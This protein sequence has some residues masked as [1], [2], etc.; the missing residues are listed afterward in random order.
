MEF[1]ID[2]GY[3]VFARI[4]DLI[5]F[6]EPDDYS[7]VLFLY[8][9]IN[10][11]VALIVG[12]IFFFIVLIILIK[13]FRKMF[14]STKPRPSRK[15]AI[16]LIDNSSLP[17]NIIAQS[18]GP[19]TSKS[20]LYNISDN[21]EDKDR[22]WLAMQYKEEERS[23]ATCIAGEIV[24]TIQAKPMSAKELKRSHRNDCDAELNYQDH[25]RNHNKQ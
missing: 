1:F 25:R 4:F 14:K 5:D 7:F 8:R 21:L 6:I 12:L 16:G 10:N 13:I 19:K 3:W 20:S 11:E 2:I 15:K 17:S 23:R 24:S 9:N 18:K 22:D